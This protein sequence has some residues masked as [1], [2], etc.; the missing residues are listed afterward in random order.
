MKRVLVIGFGRIARRH[1]DVIMSDSGFE[2]AGIVEIDP[3]RAQEALSFS[4]NVFDNIEEGLSKLSPDLAVICTES[5]SHAK[6][7][8][9]V[10]RYCSTLLVEKPMALTHE[11]TQKML[12]SAREYGCRLNI[13]QQNR[14]NLPI[15]R[16]KEAVVHGELGQIFGAQVNVFWNREADYYDQ[17]AWRG[18]WKKDGGTLS[19]QANH[20]VD[21]LLYLM[22]EPKAVFGRASSARGIVEADDL[23]VALLEFDDGALATLFATTAVRPR[24]QEASLTLISERGFLR[25]G[26][27][28]V[29]QIT[30]CTVP[31]FDLASEEVVDVY[32]NGHKALYAHLAEN[33]DT[34]PTE[35][36]SPVS[37]AKTVK[38]VERIYAA[39]FEFGDFRDANGLAPKL[40]EQ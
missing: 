21:L 2:L 39:A 28:A 36:T 31:G 40:G 34:L 23:S 16:L 24:N 13:V 11:E 6:H 32:G 30:D 37:A 25:V 12:H 33:W 27:V 3:S 17:D 9:L 5:G 22:G 20:H 19:N 26:G 18:T 38:T 10:M 15:M 8:I 35:V 29:N 4:E 14:L 1:I 7:A